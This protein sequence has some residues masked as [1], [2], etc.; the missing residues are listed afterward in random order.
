MEERRD[1]KI[2][3]GLLVL[4]CLAIL[5]LSAIACFAGGPI[6]VEGADAL[7]GI[8]LVYSFE[9]S[10]SPLMFTHLQRETDEIL[11][12][13]SIESGWYDF[14]QAAGRTFSSRLVVVRFKGNCDVATTSG[15]MTSGAL[16]YTHVTEG[17]VLPFVEVHCDKIWGFIRHEVERRPGQAA[18][19][20]AR[21]LSRVLAH[22]LYH[23]I[24][25]TG[26]H[27]R[28]GVTKAFLTAKELTQGAL[29]F[30]EPASAQI[31]YKLGQRGYG[32]VLNA[33]GGM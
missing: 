33:D 31:L 14:Q 4:N 10:Y 17:E 16:G 32:S 5:F 19:L 18:Q 20:F 26:K 9:S 12:S 15:K 25:A 28:E 1:N 6:V 29:P 27:S 22:E 13:L 7:H 30:D 11:S 3:K 24:G 8:A 2:Q 23:V 21:A